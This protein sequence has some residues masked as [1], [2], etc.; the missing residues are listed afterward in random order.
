MIIQTV[1]GKLEI[2]MQGQ[3]F[4]VKILDGPF[5]GKKVS[6]RAIS[7]IRKGLPLILSTD[8]VDILKTSNIV[9]VEGS[10]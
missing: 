7:S 10:L 2:K 9:S 3:I 1:K 4:E 8:G 5:T 6:G